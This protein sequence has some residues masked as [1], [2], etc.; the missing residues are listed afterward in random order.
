[1]AIS[2]V[3][4]VKKILGHFKVE[5]SGLRVLIPKFSTLTTTSKLKKKIKYLI[6]KSKKFLRK[7]KILLPNNLVLN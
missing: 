3:N 7:S 2:K 5:I 1:M 6:S 4:F